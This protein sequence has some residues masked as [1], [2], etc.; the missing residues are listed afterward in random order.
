[1]ELTAGLCTEQPAINNGRSWFSMSSRRVT[2][3]MFHDR[4]E[5]E[6]KAPKSSL[7]WHRKRKRLSTWSR[8]WKQERSPLITV[9]MFLS[10]SK[11][12]NRTCSASRIINQSSWVDSTREATCPDMVTG[13]QYCFV[14]GGTVSSSTQVNT[15]TSLFDKTEANKHKFVKLRLGVGKKNKGDKRG[16]PVCLYQVSV[17]ATMQWTVFRRAEAARRSSCKL[18]S[19]SLRLGSQDCTVRPAW[20]SSSKSVPYIQSDNDCSLIGILEHTLRREIS[21]ESMNENQHPRATK[22]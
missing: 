19:Q 13:T 22:H 14:R 21:N 17:L 10:T 2:R 6:S 11:D 18:L 5:V 20:Y 8:H 3:S 7:F 1:M 4:I 12:K 16:I 9:Q 15:W